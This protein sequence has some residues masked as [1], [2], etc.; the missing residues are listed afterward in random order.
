M[1]KTASR[2]LR[3]CAMGFSAETIAG[4]TGYTVFTIYRTLAD[5]RQLLGA[6]NLPHLI[7]IAIS[8]GYLD[9][10]DFIPPVA[11]KDHL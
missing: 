3:L 7:A 4:M 2:V 9:P 1:L 10:K 8:L 5:L 11:D 6:L